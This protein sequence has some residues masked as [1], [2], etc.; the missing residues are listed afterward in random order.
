MSTFW[1]PEML[2]WLRPR[3]LTEGKTIFKDQFGIARKVFNARN[4]ICGQ[5]GATESF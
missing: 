1:E 5:W 4:L 2:I 3:L